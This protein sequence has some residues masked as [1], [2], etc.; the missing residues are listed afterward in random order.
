VAAQIEFCLL[1]PLTVRRGGVAV[2]VPQGK[3]RVILAMLLLNANQI[4]R[5]DELAE[6]LWV[7]GPPPSGPVAVQN[8]L[9]RLR[10]TLGDAGRD[11]IITRPHGYLIRVTASEL[12]VTR[13]EALLGAAREAAR[14][15][16]WDQAATHARAAL[17][18]WRGEPLADVDSETLSA[19]EVPRLAELRLQAQETRI[20]ADLHLGRHTDVITE[21]RQLAGAHPL[22]ERL[23]AQLMLAFYRD[24]RQAEA[25][26]AYQ[27]AREILVAELGTEPGTELRRVHQQ[28]LT[29][30]PALAASEPAQ[31]VAGSAGPAVPQELPARVR[32]FTGRAGELA[33]LTGLLDQAGD[34]TPGTLVITAI[35]G[36]AGVGKTNHRANTPDRYQF[37]T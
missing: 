13:F 10:N 6:T 19:R 14:D 23:H 30:D 37:A 7:A 8:Y 12:D 24:G 20:D 33:T 28:I 34:E 11:R 4:V 31:P 27:A 35:G 32:H 29:G 36:T 16:S 9:M 17:E 15:G 25:L 3:Q 18:L 2:T 26:A 5:L 1:G 21:L 22:R